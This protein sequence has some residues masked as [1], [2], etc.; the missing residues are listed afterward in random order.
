M[1]HTLPEQRKACPSIHHPFDQLELGI[2]ALH[3]AI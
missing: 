3:L 2:L 1:K